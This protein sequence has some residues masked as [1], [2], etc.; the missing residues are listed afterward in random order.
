MTKFGDLVVHAQRCDELAEMCTDRTI[1]LKLR[2]LAVEY[3]DMAEHSTIVT[4]VLGMKRCPLCG[5]PQS[6]GGFGIKAPRFA[7][8]AGASEELA[9]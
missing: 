9:C 8:S 5:T 3:R 6:S 2:A 7:V 4:P 1:A